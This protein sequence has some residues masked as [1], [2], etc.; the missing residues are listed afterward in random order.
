[1]KEKNMQISLYGKIKEKREVEGEWLIGANTQNISY[2][3]IVATQHKTKAL[4]A[5][6]DEG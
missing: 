5:P 4:K 1:M 3:V 2:L 6:T